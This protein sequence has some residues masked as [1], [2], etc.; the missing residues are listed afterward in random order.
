MAVTDALINRVVGFLE[1]DITH[2]SVGTG[3]E[4]S[5]ASTTLASESLRKLTTKFIDETTLIC[6]GYWDE[7]EGNGVTY[8]N[9]G[10]FGNGATD[11]LG[12]GEL[13]AGGGINIPKTNTQSMT[14]SI[15]ITVEQI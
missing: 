5:E 12:T 11:S 10:V 3:A 6:E 8:T 14:V 15:E 1:G 7:N 13:F 2:I 4:P 9:A